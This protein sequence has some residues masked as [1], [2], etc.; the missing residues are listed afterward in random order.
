MQR[1]PRR[2]LVSCLVC[3][4]FLVM[5]STGARAQEEG[6]WLRVLGTAQDGGI[7]HAACTCRRCEAAR[8]DPARRRLIASLAL[9]VPGEDEHRRVY[10]VDATPDIRDQLESLRDVRDAPVGRVDR[11][12]VDGVLLT[13]AHLGH[14]L[15]LAFFGFEAVSTTRLPVH[16]TPA[17]A[18]YLRSNGPWD[19]LV[20]LENIALHS[21]RVGEPFDL[22]GVRITPILVPHRD[23]YSDTV[24]YRFEGPERTVLYLPDTEPWRTWEAPL[25]DPASIFEGVDV[26]IVDGSFYSPDELP[27]R[28][29]SAIGHP[30]MTETMDLLARR[31][32][33]GTLEVFFTHLNHS[34][35]ALEPDSDALK[36]IHRRGFHVLEE[37]QVFPLE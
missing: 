18:E 1:A 34:N 27:G 8:T 10:L 9:I 33:E 20:R 6:P 22:D 26:A 3:L 23:E 12:P 14:Y 16:C 37:G 2:G 28:A 25:P 36:E 31:V 17:M 15:G 13:H 29:V 4:V 19:Q 24:A 7:P 21:H 35:P 11:D 30:L 5:A 32:G